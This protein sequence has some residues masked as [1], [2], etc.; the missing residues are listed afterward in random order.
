ME[1]L[2][3]LAIGANIKVWINDELISDLNDEAKLKSHPKGFIGLQVTAS[4]VDRAPTRCAGVKSKSRNSTELPL[5]DFYNARV[6]ARAFFV[7]QVARGSSSL[8]L[9]EWRNPWR[10]H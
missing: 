10:P 1:P 7:S 5:T 3:V 4:A 8:G 2:P 9:P 6:I